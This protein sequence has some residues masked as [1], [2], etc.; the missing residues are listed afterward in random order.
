MRL[1]CAASLLLA[2][3][4]SAPSDAFATFQACYTEHHT[5]ENFDAKCSIEICCI[6][7]QIGNTAKNV[8]CGATAQSCTTYVT[9][10]V[11]D[12]SDAMLGSDI[13]TACNNYLVDSGR[14]GGTG[15][16][17]MCGS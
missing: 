8:V 17:G 9:G 6:D 5:T 15:S 12:G 2:C 7:H 1:I 10:N 13:A 16:G 3:G 11:M 4:N 14:S